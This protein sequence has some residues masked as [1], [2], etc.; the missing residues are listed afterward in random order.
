MGQVQRHAI[1]MKESTAFIPNCCI[2]ICD[3]HSTLASPVHSLNVN[4]HISKSLTN[5]HEII[6][7][8]IV[9]IQTSQLDCYPILSEKQRVGVANFKRQAELSTGTQFHFQ[10]VGSFQGRI[11]AGFVSFSLKMVYS[12]KCMGKCLKSYILL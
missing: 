6:W 7:N 10:L 2:L 3:P 1:I 8:H 4:V 12:Q 5:I 11:L 9:C